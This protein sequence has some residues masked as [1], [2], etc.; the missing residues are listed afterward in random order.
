[1]SN[2]QKR[3][4]LR[5]LAGTAAAMMLPVRQASAAPYSGAKPRIAVVYVSKTG[6]T[7]SVAEAIRRVSGADLYEV[8]T[9]EPYPEDYGETTE[10]VQK[11]IE[12]GVKRP[13]VPFDFPLDR[14]DVVILGTPTWWHHVAQPLR[15]W[16]ETVDIT[17]KYVATFNTHGG[18]GLMQTRADFE[19]MLPGVRLGTHL[20]EYGSVSGDSEARNWLRENQLI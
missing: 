15:T 14:Y 4:F 8:R 13:I 16:M 12:E 19:A 11:E 5:L 9:Q 2:I 20:T 3:T 18:G 1:M 10:V 7:R 6:N 17:G